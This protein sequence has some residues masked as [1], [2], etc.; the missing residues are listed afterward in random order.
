MPKVPSISYGRCCL[1]SAAEN[2][3]RGD[4][5]EEQRRSLEA[6]AEGDPAAGRVGRHAHI[7]GVGLVGIPTERALGVLERHVTAADA[8]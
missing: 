6:R 7:S 1:R 2:T 8:G 4:V 5:G 3:H